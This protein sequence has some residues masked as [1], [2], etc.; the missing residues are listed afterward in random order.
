MGIIGFK[1]CA[2]YSLFSPEINLWLNLSNF[3]TLEKESCKKCNKVSACVC[4]VLSIGTY[5]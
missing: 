1:G 3:N 2:E 4:I 5:Q